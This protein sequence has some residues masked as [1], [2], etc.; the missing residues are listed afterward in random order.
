[1]GGM[2]TAA[3]RRI[4]SFQKYGRPQSQTVLTFSP[5]M[6][7]D[8][9]RARLV[10]QGKMRDD[11]ALVNIWQDLR[12]RTESELETL[13]GEPLRAPVPEEDGEVENINAFYD[14]FRSSGTG[15][16]IRRNYL[17]AD[18]SLLLTDVRDPKL[19]TRFILHSPSGTPMTEW[20]RPR[21]F[22]NAWIS[23]FVT[24]AP[25]VVIVDDKKVSEFIHEISDRHFG[26]LLF[27]HGSHLRH[28]WNGP[29]GQVL[30]YRLDT[31]RNFDRFD[32]VG[33][34]TRQQ[35]E[36]IRAMGLSGENIRL[37]TGELPAGAVLSDESMQRSRN[38]AVMIANLIALKR[39]D[40][41]IRAVAKLRDRGIDVSLT[42]LGEG[43]E[44]PKLEKLI[45]TL[46]VG[47]RVAL[48]GYVNDV[49]DKL[50]AASFSMLT[51][52]SEGLPLSLMESMGAGC[53]PIVYDITYGPRDLIA[54][55]E[56]GYITP[57]SDIGALADQIEDFLSLTPESV[58]AM[59]KSAMEAV[60]RYLPDA[61]YE[62]WR[63]VLEELRPSKQ[64]DDPNGEAVQPIATKKL[65]CEPISDGSRIELE[66][67][68]L[69]GR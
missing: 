43:P 68:R 46:D 41:P 30:P 5:R 58:E 40:H 4:H 53:I 56:N 14:A 57:R 54:Q 55:G 33:V 37:L 21:D 44:R 18:G 8:E 19:G 52:T 61:G 16:V 20:R 69:T 47:D 34:Q 62:R 1:M 51:S 17:R 45:D 3:L 23:A 6:D 7:P 39:V 66:F 15:P 35:A 60:E 13:V 49:P 59:R 31:M 48:P 10:S 63:T 2:T 64:Y 26:L 42:V 25:A 50:K 24:K 38:Q 22:Y 36:A 65:K 28:P 9:T 27:L 29:H 32:I 11:V 67:D 12:N